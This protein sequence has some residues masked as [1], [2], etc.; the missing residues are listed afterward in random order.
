MV[1]LSGCVK[2]A[3]FDALTDRVATLEAELPTVKEQIAT[4]QSALSTL[5]ADVNAQLA[6]VNG[7]LTDLDDAA[8][9]AKTKLDELEK[10]LATQVAALKSELK[11]DITNLETQLGAATSQNAEAIA[12]LQT[13]LG[14]I[15]GTLEK[16]DETYATDADL[17]AAVEQLTAAIDAAEAELTFTLGKTFQDALKGYAELARVETLE[18]KVNGIDLEQVKADYTKAIN[19]AIAAAVAEGGVISE[20]VKAQVAALV[21]GLQGQ[22]D[23]LSGKLDAVIGRIQSV[24]FVPEYTDCKAT[25]NYATV[26]TAVLEM[27]STL[28][29]QVT[30][31]ECAD[32][33]AKGAQ[34]FLSFNFQTLK[35]RAAAQPSLVAESAKVVDAAKGII[36]VTVKASNLAAGFYK[37]GSVDYAV[38]LVV[39]YADEAKVNASANLASSYVK[40]Y[41][42]EYAYNVKVVDDAPLAYEIEYTNTEVVR[43]I[44]KSNSLKFTRANVDYTLAEMKAMGLELSVTPDVV[45]E[46]KKPEVFNNVPTKTEDHIYSSVNLTNK[47]VKGDVGLTQ[48][49]KYIYTVKADDVVKGTTVDATTVSSKVATITVVKPQR[50]ID[51]IFNNNKSDDA[52]LNYINWNY[53]EDAISDVTGNET[54]SVDV[55]AVKETTVPTDT[56]WADILKAP[57]KTTTVTVDGKVV[58]GVEAIFGEAADKAQ[59]L[60][61]KKFAW[62]K[63]YTITTKYELAHIDVTVSITVHTVD[64]SRDVIVLP[65]QDWEVLYGY[66]LDVTST[67]ESLANIFTQVTKEAENKSNDFSNFK[68]A[69]EYLKTVL[70]DTTSGDYKLNA[71][72]VKAT[73]SDGSTATYTSAESKLT[74]GKDGSDMSARYFYGSD[75]TATPVTVEYLY[76]VTTWY[77]QRIKVTKVLSINRAGI[78][79]FEYVPSWVTPGIISVVTPEYYTNEGGLYNYSLQAI[80]LREAFLVIPGKLQYTDEDLQKHHLKLEYTASTNDGLDLSSLIN[81]KLELQYPAY[82][83]NVDPYQSSINVV[84]H[85]YLASGINDEY[86]E[87]VTKFDS[88]YKNYQVENVDA[89]TPAFEYNPEIDRENIT[90]VLND[91]KQ[92]SYN[93]WNLLQAKDRRGELVFENGA[94]VVGNNTNGFA[95]NSLQ[96]GKPVTPADDEIYGATMKFFMDPG[97][98]GEELLRKRPEMV[99]VN[100]NDNAIIHL[101][102]NTGKLYVDYT[103][104]FELTSPVKV[105]ITAK[106]TQKYGKAFTSEKITITIVATK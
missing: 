61:L 86:V 83:T 44:M 105:H 53:L 92:Y 38:S 37:G 15:K 80:K 34:T 24:V 46:T 60:T 7:K 85:L 95:A 26:G 2:R 65:L 20:A 96:T 77:G 18:E 43:E 4:L 59:T 21:A 87:L 25:I 50:K 70:L 52:T 22:L 76:D 12:T 41:P 89:I 33:L 36:E 93:V 10:D 66:K 78:Y 103:Q 14:T 68:N 69:A 1:L 71:C 35:S 99:S 29:Y 13:T 28:K 19:D 16:L 40:L 100:G 64:R 58:T 102:E 97:N 106:M 27:K 63:V 62:G 67:P 56:P 39:N 51:F 74:L 101:D 3:D 17:A 47:V 82:P 48:T 6:T 73:Y 72:T 5:E 79:D 90:I 57:K 75:F 94:W 54:Q 49:V 55:L 30:P 91:A 11:G 32:A 81:N 9:S 104:K 23:A 45:Y 8:A 31:A 84:G 42:A 98:A 88:D